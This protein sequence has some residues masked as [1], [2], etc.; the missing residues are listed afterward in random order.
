[1]T[2]FNAR[3]FLTVRSSQAY[4]YLFNLLTDGNGSGN[5]STI[6]FS[7][8]A[9]LSLSL[10]L[11]LFLPLSGSYYIPLL[12]LS[13]PPKPN[14]NQPTSHVGHHFFFF[15]FF[16]FCCCCLMQRLKHIKLASLPHCLSAHV[17]VTRL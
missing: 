15:F 12:L 11:S 5:S 10:S 3:I 8:L 7:P 17:R 9:S 6:L 4:R 1:M 13:N 16:F 2:S 14:T